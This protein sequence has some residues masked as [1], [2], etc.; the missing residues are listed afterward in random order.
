MRISS[1]FGVTAG[2]TDFS[3]L[4]SKT[5]SI[6]IKMSSLRGLGYLGPKES[7]IFASEFWIFSVTSTVSLTMVS[8][9]IAGFNV[10]LGNALVVDVEDSLLTG[11]IFNSVVVGEM[12]SAFTSSVV[13]FSF[14]VVVVVV[15]I[16]VVVAVVVKEGVVLS[17][18]ELKVV[19]GV[20]WQTP[21]TL[22]KISGVVSK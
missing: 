12:L 20:D 1:F 3:V 2:V 6:S 8:P 15:V 10:E 21:N 11:S 22:Q 7:S 13:V 16:V 17:E 19:V 14:V 5:S 9:E 4:V 18:V